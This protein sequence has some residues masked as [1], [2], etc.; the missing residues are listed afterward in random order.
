MWELIV[1]V[2]YIKAT[3]AYLMFKE[4]LTQ[5]YHAVIIL[6]DSVETVTDQQYVSKTVIIFSS[7]GQ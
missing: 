1:F 6:S 3:W 2:F 4:I 5:H 7:G